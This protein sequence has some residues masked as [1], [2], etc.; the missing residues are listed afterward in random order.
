MSRITTHVLD[1]ARG[2]PADNVSV[3]LE[4]HSR[5]SGWL[6]LAERRTDTDGRV[7]NLLAE[8]THPPAGRYRITFGTGEYFHSLGMRCF[9]PEVEVTFE[10]EDSE[11]H[12]HV[13]LLVSPFGYSTYRGS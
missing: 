5:E 4:Q 11:Q 1:L 6:I 8:A 10:I 3:K 7:K 12:Y 9:H 2:K 13:P